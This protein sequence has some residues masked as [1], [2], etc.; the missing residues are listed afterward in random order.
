MGEGAEGGRGEG[1]G[2]GVEGWGRGHGVG[3]GLLREPL[4]A[5]QRAAHVWRCIP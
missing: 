3:E 2:G 5:Q 1:G 4:R